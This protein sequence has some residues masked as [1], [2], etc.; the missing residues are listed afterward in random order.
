M[1]EFSKEQRKVR[2]VVK[3]VWLSLCMSQ[4][5]HCETTRNISTPPGIG[6]ESIAGLHTAL[7]LPISIYT[8][9]WRGT[10]RVM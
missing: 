10:V 5:A 9:G 1:R 8:L 2:S 6:S 3:R 7:N 4:V